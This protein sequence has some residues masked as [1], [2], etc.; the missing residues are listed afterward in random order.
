M[1]LEQIDTSTMAGKALPD[2]CPVCGAHWSV[3]IAYT[4]VNGF[5]GS[6]ADLAGE[7]KI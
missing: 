5:H 7:G 2:R 6:R 4:C 3:H 1:N